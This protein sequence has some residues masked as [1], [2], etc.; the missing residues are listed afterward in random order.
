MFLAREA[1]PES[2]LS[3][4][5]SA[6]SN[7]KP[8]VE[9]TAAIIPCSSPS[10]EIGQTMRVCMVLTSICLLTRRSSVVS[11]MKMVSS[12]AA[13]FPRK[14]LLSLMILSRTFWYLAVSGLWIG[15]SKFWRCGKF[16]SCV[17]A[18]SF[19]PDLSRKKI[20]RDSAWMASVM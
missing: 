16:P 1:W 13:A 6:F 15:L 11:L 5:R 12:L 7:G 3:S 14:P 19:L 2:D 9:F 20:H 17:T 10:I 18:L 8:S 4:R